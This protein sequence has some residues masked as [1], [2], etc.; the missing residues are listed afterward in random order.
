MLHIAVIN[1]NNNIVKLLLKNFDN[2][3]KADNREMR[4]IHYAALKGE[5]HIVEELVKFQL[6]KSDE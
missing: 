5:L 3:D 1:K 2:I 4:A 6:R